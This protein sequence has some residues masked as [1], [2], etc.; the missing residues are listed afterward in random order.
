[1]TG[2]SPLVLIVED[3]DDQ[4][5][6]LRRQFERAGCTVVEAP[7]AATAEALL[8]ERNPGI[9]V[10]DLL[11]PDTNGWTLS[12][13]VRALAPE[14]ALVISSVLDAHDYPAA[15]AVLPKPVTSAQVRSLVDRVV[16]G[17]E[18]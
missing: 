9:V 12:S 11:M 1:M 15:D 6:L 14:A 18:R 5:A 7:D 10:L 4:R 17:A 2:P 13:R 8:S 16:A 3:S